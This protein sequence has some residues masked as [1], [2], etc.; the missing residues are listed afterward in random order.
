LRVQCGHDTGQVVTPIIVDDDH[1][2]E[3]DVGGL[4]DRPLLAAQR[5]AHNPGINALF[6]SI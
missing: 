4:F 2:E 6:S 5:D 1:R 3:R